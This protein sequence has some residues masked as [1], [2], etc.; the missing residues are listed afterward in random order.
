MGAPAQAGLHAG[1]DL[2]AQMS[3]ESGD[4][5][6]GCFFGRRRHLTI[7]ASS[8]WAYSEAHAALDVFD[9]LAKPKGHVRHSWTFIW[10]GHQDQPCDE[11]SQ[12]MGSAGL[13]IL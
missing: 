6:L 5:P 7:S 2:W 8:F 13:P 11:A 3:S 1:L 10:A 9:A 4:C 12:A